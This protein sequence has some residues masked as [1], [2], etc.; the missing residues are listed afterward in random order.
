MGVNNRNSPRIFVR[1][2]AGGTPPPLPLSESLG[3]EKKRESAALALYNTKQHRVRIERDQSVIMNL[4]K[5][6]SSFVSLAAASFARRWLRRCRR[7]AAAACLPR[8]GERDRLPAVGVN[9]VVS[10]PVPDLVEMTR[11][12]SPHE[13]VQRVSAHGEHSARVHDVVIVEGER[14]GRGVHRPLVDH[15]LAVVLAVPLE[16]R[17]LE[18]AVGRREETDVSHLSRVIFVLG[19]CVSECLLSLCRRQII[20]ASGLRLCESLVSV[21]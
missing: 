16:L 17:Q 10:L 5:K 6:I 8:A 11:E 7:A 18:E 20:E 15:G 1:T 21:T 14:L 12:P 9:T 13:H 19:A 4:S 3:G 2:S